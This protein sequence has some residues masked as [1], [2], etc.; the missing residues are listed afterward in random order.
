MLHQNQVSCLCCK[1]QFSVD[2]LMEI[3]SPT[4]YT[5][6]SG[7]TQFILLSLDS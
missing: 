7:Y 4:P 5:L 2:F 3:H 6:D 1:L